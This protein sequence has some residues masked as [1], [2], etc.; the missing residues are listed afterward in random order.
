[1]CSGPLT[2]Q[3]SRVSLLMIVL[4][5]LPLPNR[6]KRRLRKRKRDQG[7]DY[8]EHVWACQSVRPESQEFRVVR[9]D[10]AHISAIAV[11]PPSGLNNNISSPSILGHASTSPAE[12][13]TQQVLPDSDGDTVTEE[14]TQLETCRKIAQWSDDP[15]SPTRVGHPVQGREVLEYHDG[16]NSTTILGELFGQKRPRRFV[17]ILLREP[18][19]MEQGQRV[20]TENANMEF[21]RRQGAFSLPQRLTC[22]KLLHLYF[23][24]VHPYTPILDRL[25]FMREFK[26]GTF[27]MFLMQCI[28]TCVVPYVPNELLAEI[29]HLDRFSA[30]KS[31]FSNAQLLYDLGAEKSQFCL[32]Q[33]SLALTSVHFSF[34][35]DKDCRFWLTN[36]VRLATQMGLHR[37]QMVDQLDA[38][39][40][41]LFTRAFWVLY[42]KDVL[43]AIA[44]RCNVRRLNDRHIDLPEV[45]EDD[46]EEDGDI[47]GFQHVLSPITRI[48]KLYIVHNTRL[49]RIC[50]QYIESFRA[51]N[52]TRLGSACGELEQAISQWRR[53]LPA[54]LHTDS[55]GDW[56]TDEIWIL[57]LKAMSYRLECVLYRNL[58]EL[59]AGEEN[60]SRR[61]LQKQQDA[62]L[63]LDAI[64]DR[65]ML[66][67]LV[68]S[69][70]L[71]LSTC[72]S[73]VIAMH[74]EIALST[75]STIPQRRA[76]RTHI[77][78]GLS[79][80]RA[81][82]EYWDSIRGNLRMFE[83]IVAGTGLS[84]GGPDLCD[85][86]LTSMN[87]FMR[88]DSSKRA[89][90]VNDHVTDSF[91]I[92]DALNS[93]WSGFQSRAAFDVAEV[94]FSYEPLLAEDPEKWL[95]EL[96]GES[97]F[98]MNSSIYSAAHLS[99]LSIAMLPPH[100]INHRTSRTRQKKVR[101]SKRREKRS[102]M[103]KTYQERAAE[104]RAYQVSLIPKEWRLSAIP[105]IESVPD[106]LEYIRTSGLLSPEELSLTETTDASILLHRLLKREIS[107]L[108]VVRAFAKRAA[109]AH[110]LTTCC[111][112]IFFEEAFEQ[113][114]E[115][116][117]VL[118]RTGKPVGPLHGLPVSIKDAID[119]KGKDTS[120][121]WVGLTNRPA[122]EDAHAA[123][124]LRK[125][126]AVL[127]VKTNVPQSMMMSD[128][129]NHVFGQC[130][131][132][133]NRALISGGS[134]GG[135]SSLISA[136]GS[137]LGIGTD[138]GGSI[139]IPAALCGLYGLTPGSGRQPYERRG[140]RQDIVRSIAGPIA[141]HLSS[142]EVYMQALPQA[143]PWE[144]DPYVYPLPWRTERCSLPSTQKLRIGFIIDDGVVKPQ[145]PVMRAVE[146]VVAALKSAGHEVIEW[147]ATSHAHAYDLWEKAIL[148]DGGAACQ[149]LCDMSG[150]PLIEGM[151]VGTAKDLLTTAQTHQLI[152]NKYDYETS[153]LR[154]WQAAGLDA[155]IMPVT[156][157]VGY[158]PWTWVKSHQ[159]VGYTSIWN[160]L[161]WPALAVPVT[162]VTKEKDEMVSQEWKTH[163]GRNKA[164]EFN[165]QQY[166]IDLVDGMPVGVQI[167]SG[168]YE[169]EKCIA[170]AKVI[171]GLLNESSRKGGFKL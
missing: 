93:A 50:A 14:D 95:N 105:S 46:L 13:A 4:H 114:K 9:E 55:V 11:H 159:Y 63:E 139:R 170:V 41:K 1:M 125:L 96:I 119:V 89:S 66:H 67:D 43:M 166:D 79:Y 150:E 101:E 87:P 162:T 168:K 138:I 24:L 134:S 64:L 68:A 160:L 78:N 104:K 44:G 73:T 110:Q 103:V 165:K 151:L 169:E 144:D 18:A 121:G 25:V 118:A 90:Y 31:F 12:W 106:A 20:G 108:Q 42:N 83:V 47:E 38:S 45:T 29:G 56:T 62:M 154:R 153:Y 71:A 109:I 155:L 135:E 28:L 133:L 152:A 129:Y 85:L 36:S 92:P 32:F 72:A 99:N 58:K 131:N 124:A 7:R 5:S 3:I 157:W 97:V 158:K 116:D 81:S 127:Y 123:K 76:N 120:I 30:Q 39:A 59:C 40:R 80:L 17:R 126:G 84:L 137:V 111:T 49:A 112:E 77:Y 8:Q 128:S 51:P 2:R 156:P 6:E 19:P 132:S 37:K 117:D 35:L 22:E 52:S 167:V 143:K 107:S 98:G 149:K 142:I 27:S 161:D 136:R 147:D 100:V 16:V 140:V 86:D 65:V 21:L 88:I 54:E 69:C 15:V 75:S 74:I 102:K 141:T 146:E 60:S 26:D 23:E 164:D 171:K 70:P 148:S 91:R 57:V 48:Q 33:G 113:A 61:A 145:P 82:S 163:Q 122:A 94:D 115:L 10:N 53:S 130:V 34:G